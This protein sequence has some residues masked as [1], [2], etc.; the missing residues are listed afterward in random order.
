MTVTGG[1]NDVFFRTS[2][3]TDQD[4]RHLHLPDSM[5][6]VSI[7]ITRNAVRLVFHV[8]RKLLWHCAVITCFDITV[9]MGIRAKA[10]MWSLKANV[11]NNN[12]ICF[13]TKS[14]IHW[15]CSTYYICIHGWCFIFLFTW[16]FLSYLLYDFRISE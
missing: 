3:S 12:G 8:F 1:V 5:K 14:R 4:S 6:N 11:D 13:T 2:I 9:L 7:N 10:K 16:F 15:V